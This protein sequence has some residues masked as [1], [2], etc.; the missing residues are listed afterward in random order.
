MFEPKTYWEKRASLTE[1]F[2]EQL[3]R[4]WPSDQQEQIVPLRTKYQME[5]YYLRCAESAEVVGTPADLTKIAGLAQIKSLLEHNLGRGYWQNH[6]AAV[7]PA[8]DTCIGGTAYARKFR[9]F[10]DGLPSISTAVRADMPSQFVADLGRSRN[11]DVPSIPTLVIRGH[12]DEAGDTLNFITVFGALS[13]E[14][15]YLDHMPAQFPWTL[16]DYWRSEAVRYLGHMTLLDLVVG[17]GQALQAQ[18]QTRLVI[19]FELSD[20]DLATATEKLEGVEVIYNPPKPDTDAPDDEAPAL[21]A[22]ESEAPATE[23]PSESTL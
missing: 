21:E 7:T 16:Q 10:M 1:A 18:Q 5:Q 3:V 19:P 15:I 2:V 6:N 12:T 11:P 8:A 17:L 23:V 4:R 13:V 22:V 20:A 9:E 14:T